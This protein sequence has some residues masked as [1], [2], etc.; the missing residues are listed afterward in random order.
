MLTL[1]RNHGKSEAVRQGMLEASKQPLTFLGYFDAD[2]ATPVDELLRLVSIIEADDNLEA[3]FGSRG[4]AKLGSSIVRT[5]LRHYLGRVYATAASIA[6]GVVVYDT[7]CGA[8]VFRMNPCAPRG[9]KGAV[10][11]VLGLRCRASGSALR[12]TGSSP[13]IP[14]K[15]F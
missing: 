3:V 11:L 12:G 2:L 4:A 9:N 15:S 6:V 10:R 7:Q 5:P 1:S 14:V 13:G 8:K